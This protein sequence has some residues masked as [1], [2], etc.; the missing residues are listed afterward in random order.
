MDLCSAQLHCSDLP[1]PSLA[2]ISCFKWSWWA[3]LVCTEQK[4]LVIPF[5]TKHLD[6][7]RLLSWQLKRDT[8]KSAAELWRGNLRGLRSGL[9]LPLQ[10]E[11]PVLQWSPSAMQCMPKQYS[12]CRETWTGFYLLACAQSSNICSDQIRSW[13]EKSPP[14]SE[15][16]IVC[17]SSATSWPGDC[18]VSHE[19][20]SIS[21][22]INVLNLLCSMLLFHG[23]KEANIVN[24]H[25]IAWNICV[26]LFLNRL[27]LWWAWYGFWCSILPAGMCSGFEYHHTK[28]IKH[29]QIWKYHSIFLNTEINY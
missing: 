24:W 29:L 15:L 25:R 14:L 9:Q 10:V 17:F 28:K 20:W 6:V 11:L 16:V 12:V 21:C 19:D 8:D 27:M 26:S 7:L 13:R 18:R 23:R 22:D 2:P 1:C 4:C 3:F 5:L